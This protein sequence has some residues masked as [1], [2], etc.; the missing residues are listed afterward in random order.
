MMLQGV[1]AVCLA[2]TQAAQAGQAHRLLCN[3]GPALA[4]QLSWVVKGRHL[5]CTLPRLLSQAAFPA[6]LPQV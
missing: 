6:V 2:L 3:L 5:S 1:P 4:L